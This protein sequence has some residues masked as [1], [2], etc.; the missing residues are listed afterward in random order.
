MNCHVYLR[1]G[2]VYVPTMGKMDKGF[3][4]GVEPVAALSVANTAGVREAL[5]AAIT[6][7]N[8]IVPLLL[9]REWGP[10]ILLKYAGLKYWSDFE[11]GM[12]FWTIKE[13]NGMFQIA[14]QSKQIDAMWRDDPAQTITFQPRSAADEVIERMIAILQDAARR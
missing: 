3:Y 1:K 6:R 7:G 9:R 13:K 8:P 14:G 4:R 5:R 12:L 11:R 2:T 10:P